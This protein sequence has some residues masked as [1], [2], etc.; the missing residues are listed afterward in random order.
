MKERPIANIFNGEKLNAF[1]LKTG[2]RH[3][4]LSSPIVLEVLTSA[5]RQNK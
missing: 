5:I 4:C 1:L 2:I 3:R